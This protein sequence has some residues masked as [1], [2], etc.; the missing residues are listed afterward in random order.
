MDYDNHRS[1]SKARRKLIP[2]RVLLWGKEIAVDWAQPESE[3]EDEIMSKVS[4]CQALMCRLFNPIFSYC[5]FQVT[6]LYVRN[7]SMTTTEQE[8]RNVFNAYSDGQVTKLKM[9]RDFAFVHFNT[10]QDAEIAMF[11]A[12]RKMLYCFSCCQSFKQ[13]C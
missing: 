3:V 13:P 8:L 4:F 2:D 9:M 1:A 11:A 10:R 6:V 12:N 7:L 5:A